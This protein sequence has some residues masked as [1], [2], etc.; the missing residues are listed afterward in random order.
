L[1]PGRGA[2]DRLRGVFDS[3]AQERQDTKDEAEERNSLEPQVGQA[4]AAAEAAD[5]DVQ[6]LLDKARRAADRGDLG[7]A[8]DAAHAAAVQGLSAAGQVELDR[9]RTN[10]DYLRDLRK[11]PPLQQ[12]FK[13]IV[14]QVE[15]A[16]F[17]GAVPSRGAFDS[18]L[19]QVLALLRRLAVLSLFLL[20]LALLGCG[21]RGAGGSD[22]D[23]GPAGL[24]TL[25]Q[26]LPT[27][28]PKCTRASRR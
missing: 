27:K 23:R 15:I 1:G 24:Y 20:P 28:A 11:A 19:E 22:E 2:G 13:V 3:H 8:I 12:Q 5:K 16:Q 10:G 17:G 21:A 26:L 14:G 9:D 7:A 18:V 25:K 6:R 4:P